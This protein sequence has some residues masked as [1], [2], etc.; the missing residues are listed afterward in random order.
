MSTKTVDLNLEVKA[1]VHIL[2]ANQKTRHLLLSSLDN[3]HFGS[4]KTREIFVRISRL[5]AAG[6][7]LP[8]KTDMLTD[9]AL[10]KE[11]KILLKN[12]KVKRTKKPHILIEQLE[13]Y[14]QVRH[15]IRATKRSLE[16]LEDETVS[17]ESLTDVRNHLADD[18][19][20]IGTPEKLKLYHVGEETNMDETIANILKGGKDSKF[21]K[22]GLEEYDEKTGGVKRGELIIIS[23]N[24]GG[25]KS[26]LAHQISLNMYKDFNESVAVVPLEMDEEEWMERVLSC[27][28]G[29]E[30]DKIG[31]NDLT[32]EEQKKVM[33]AYKRFR[34]VGRNSGARYTVFPASFITPDE[35][36]MYLKPYN[37]SAWF[38]DYLSLVEA[39]NPTGQERVDLGNIAKAFKLY[40][41]ELNIAV[42]LLAQLN[43]ED[44]VKYAKAVVEHADRWWAWRADPEDLEVYHRIRIHQ[45]KARRSK[46]Y[47]FWL[48]EDF[49]TAS[50][51]SMPA[52]VVEE[53]EDDKK[54]KKGKRRS[55]RDSKMKGL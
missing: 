29:V 2:R 4:R 30:Y 16:I 31:R 8:S 17:I 21:L 55:A 6:K 35:I 15:L 46:L 27:L 3:K 7:E 14:K 10:S 28:S 33:N 19:A 39:T 23:A 54:G 26:T 36:A 34:K 45:K 22:T 42:Y 1:L 9:P 40:A 49:A 44:Q 12:E 11:A 50:L 18:L 24:T 52:P 38:I 51:R 32:F 48:A 47:P 43:D 20:R 41:K 25:G 37:Y 13:I 5:A 53:K